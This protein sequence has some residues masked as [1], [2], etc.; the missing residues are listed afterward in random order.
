MSCYCGCKRVGQG[1]SAQG[2]CVVV[3][4]MS[5]RM[6]DGSAGAGRGVFAVW[7]VRRHAASRATTMRTAWVALWRQG[8]TRHVDGP[9]AT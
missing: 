2:Q 1:G 5:W 6:V 4:C 8:R 3:H 9:F 7:H